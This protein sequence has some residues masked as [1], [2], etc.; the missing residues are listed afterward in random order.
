MN[1]AP[2]DMRRLAVEGIHNLRDLGGYRTRGGEL[3]PWRRFLRADSPHRL[4]ADGVTRLEAEGLGTVLDLRTAEECAAMPNPFA[5]RP[6]VTYVHQP[7][8][9]ELAPLKLAEIDI[10]GG[11]PLLDFYR[12]A[13]DDRHEALREILI[14]IAGVPEGAVMF[15]CTVGKDR[16][17]L[18]AALL[19]GLAE[20]APEDIVEDYALTGS[21][22]GQLV[23]EMLEH[24]RARGEDPDR[25]AR[26]LAA[27]AETMQAALGHIEMR[28]G[29]VSGYLTHIG[30][31][32]GDRSA[33]RDRLRGALRTPRP[34]G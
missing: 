9:E 5:N 30:V 33:L 17:G 18:V 19:L 2:R 27:P 22:I 3:T 20:V 34:V 23:A 12:I 26:L 21:L 31:P 14:T 4:T 28:Y 7:V 8:F 16:T 32:A 29:S 11:D 15:H 10:V 1:H 24:T 6:G 13:V 25:H